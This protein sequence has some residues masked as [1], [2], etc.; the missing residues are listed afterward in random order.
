MVVYVLA[1]GDEGGAINCLATTNN[2][3]YVFKSV[4]V[5]S[6][7]FSIATCLN[8]Q[9]V[10]VL[11]HVL[12]KGG[13]LDHLCASSSSCLFVLAWWDAQS[14]GKCR[15]LVADCLNGFAR[16]AGLLYKFGS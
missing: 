15:S 4:H 7:K 16:S 9:A 11:P 2:K 6:S 8:M 12:T 5:L 13:I 14:Q 3:P 1:R 10:I